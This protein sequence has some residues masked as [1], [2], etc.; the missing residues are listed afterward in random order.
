MISLLISVTFAQRTLPYSENSDLRI[1]CLAVKLTPFFCLKQEKI[2]D[3]IRNKIKAD[4][5]KV[6]FI[7][8]RT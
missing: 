6:S 8:L 1:S 2:C 5:R 4:G 7:I 3:R